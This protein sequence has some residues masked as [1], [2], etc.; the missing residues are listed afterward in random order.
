MAMTYKLWDYDI[1][2]WLL[3]AQMLFSYIC[4]LN[5]ICL[6]SVFFGLATG[7]IPMVLKLIETAGFWVNL[8]PSQYQ[9]PLEKPWEA[10]V[11]VGDYTL[12]CLVCWLVVWNIW[13]I[14]IYVPYIGNFIIPT[15]E[16][17]LFRGVGQPP[18]SYVSDHFSEFFS[19]LRGMGIRW[20]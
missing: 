13:N 15:D 16:L 2:L 9:A 10:M 19:H 4:C 3:G 11:D 17:I 14:F 8:I 7:A 5:R 12:V 20:N 18:T 6:F 1:K